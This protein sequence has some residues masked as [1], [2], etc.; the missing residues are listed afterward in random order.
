MTGMPA[1]ERGLD[2]RLDR[3]GVEGVDARTSTPGAM[4]RLDVG[5]LGLGR[6]LGVVADVLASAGLDGRLDR[7]LVAQPVALLLKGEPGH[8]D[9]AGR[10]RPRWVRGLAASSVRR[11]AA[12]GAVVRRCRYRRRMPGP[13]STGSRPSFGWTSSALLLGGR[14]AGSP[15]IVRAATWTRPGLTAWSSR[16]RRRRLDSAS[17]RGSSFPCGARRRSQPACAMSSA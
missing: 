9:L 17:V 12:L 14:S 4:Q 15:G 3:L 13:R 6:V 2:R 5:G 1:G 16:C 8:A 10:R 7:G 11:S